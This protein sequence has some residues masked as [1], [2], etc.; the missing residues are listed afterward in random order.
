MLNK[1][2]L[3]SN[4]GSQNQTPLDRALKKITAAEKVLAN[5]KQQHPD[6]KILVLGG[7][8]FVGGKLMEAGISAGMNI[9][10]T[11]RKGEFPQGKYLDVINDNNG[12]LSINEHAITDLIREEKPFAIINAIA[13]ADPYKNYKNPALARC[14]N[15]ELVKSLVKIIDNSSAK[16]KL[17]HIS[18][19]AV[20]DTGACG[21]DPLSEEAIPNPRQENF[22]A[23]TKAKGEEVLLNSSIQCIIPRPPQMIGVGPSSSPHNDIKKKL[24]SGNYTIDN[25]K[26]R[27]GAVEEVAYSL[28]CIALSETAYE[29]PIINLIGPEEY[30]LVDLAK[31][32]A[33]LFNCGSPE[34]I[35]PGSEG[36][37]PRINIVQTDFEFALKLTPEEAIALTQFR[38]SNG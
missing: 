15:I 27:F 36:D 37:M 25:T 26:R 8:G 16:P 11:F 10:G 1:K 2:I 18:T 28:L 3:K 7:S 24:E 19:D 29:Q 20:Y 14:L 5:L 38:E 17:I 34:S 21:E 12:D 31:Y 35:T 33:E 30:G 6:H 32:V 4:L 9:T 23:Y 22:Y 13:L